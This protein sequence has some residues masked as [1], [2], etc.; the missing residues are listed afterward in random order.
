MDIAQPSSDIASYY[1]MTIPLT[2][3]KKES[4]LQFLATQLKRD[5][6]S[7][8]EN[9]LSP[10]RIQ[11]EIITKDRVSKGSPAYS[12]VNTADNYYHG[13]F[14]NEFN[15]PLADLMDG[16]VTIDQAASRINQSLRKKILE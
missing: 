6:A 13:Q 16:K 12:Q 2:S 8:G 7:L 15:Q 11:E 10:Y 9:V 14:P 1:L 5:T 4:A 3:P